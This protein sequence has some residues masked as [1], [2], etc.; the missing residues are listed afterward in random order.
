MFSATSGL[1]AVSTSGQI[2]LIRT[3]GKDGLRQ[4]NTLNMESQAR[5]A[6]QAG[7]KCESQQGRRD[8]ED[9]LGVS[10]HMT[11]AN[12]QNRLPDAVGLPQH[13]EIRAGARG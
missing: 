9:P 11:G 4:S 10:T 5:F 1:R 8:A 6:C 7:G 3:L 12:G 13:R 2:S